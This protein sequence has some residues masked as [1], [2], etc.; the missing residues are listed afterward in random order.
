MLCILL[1]FI[2]RDTQI[3]RARTLWIP[4]LLAGVWMA[5][6]LQTVKIPEGLLA[7]IAPGSKAAYFDWI[8]DTIRAE[9]FKLQ[10]SNVESLASTWASTSIAP[11]LTMQALLALSLF[12]VTLFL[13]ITLSKSRH[14]IVLFLSSTCISGAVMALFA[15]LHARYPNSSTFAS[16]MFEA[17]LNTKNPFGSFINANNAAG[18]L[19]TALACGLGWLIF[20]T[21]KHR[22]L[23]RPG[24]HPSEQI[25]SW[26]E[27]NLQALA[28]RVRHLQGSTNAVALL[29]L[30]ILIGIIAS[31]SR[32]GLLGA[33]C[34]FTVLMANALGRKFG[35]NRSKT[36]IASTSIAVT[37]G[38]LVILGP[39]NRDFGSAVAE[40]P[41]AGSRIA[42]WRDATFA[43]WNYLPLGSG[44]GTYRYAYLPHQQYGD[45]EWFLN[46][47]NIYLEWIVEGGI[48]LLPTLAAICFIFAAFLQKLEDLHPRPQVRAILVTGW[49]MLI[50]LGVSQAFDFALLIPSNYI[51]VAMIVGSV[52]G[53]LD[54]NKRQPRRRSAQTR[55]HRQVKKQELIRSLPPRS[56]H[57]ESKPQLK[58]KSRSELSIQ[59]ATIALVAFLASTLFSAHRQAKAAS[60]SADILQSDD[61]TKSERF[62]EHTI[63]HFAQATEQWVEQIPSASTSPELH[64]K[65]ADLILTQE[66]YY[67][68]NELQKLG[69][70]YVTSWKSLQPQSLRRIHFNSLQN[71]SPEIRARNLFN[72]VPESSR[73]QFSS[74]RKHALEALLRCPLSLNARVALIE[75][76]FV[77]PEASSS[78]HDLLLQLVKLQRRNPKPIA[79]VRQMAEV[80]PGKKT[81]AAMNRFSL[82]QQQ[83]A[84]PDIWANVLRE[85]EL[86]TAKQNARRPV[87]GI[88]RTNQESGT[89]TE[90]N[91]PRRQS[92]VAK[93]TLDF[94]IDSL[95]QNATL[96]IDASED[97]KT[98]VEIKTALLAKANELLSDSTTQVTRDGQT[99]FDKGRL[100]E[101]Q[102]SLTSAIQHYETAIK[103]NPSKH[104]WRFRLVEALEQQQEYK[105]AE[106]HL[107]RCL[108]Q[109]PRN[110][111]Y[112]NKLRSLHTK[113]NT[114]RRG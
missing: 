24:I 87:S 47:D 48:W 17:T 112:R 4:G 32:G 78:S 19:N 84:F 42:H 7:V 79:W 73:N 18:Y 25:G 33:T 40:D 38:L 105:F 5:G 2:I 8:P 6:N 93:D 54:K 72:T 1:P 21:T 22:E 61:F 35:W 31:G 46:A 86:E 71:S 52:I 90:P 64:L 20:L 44:I 11:W 68:A 97:A 67:L 37:V 56:E 80:H 43:A 111:Q 114:R 14:F 83:A 108:L 3:V 41:T 95:P 81:I 58:P 51:L 94:A 110:E 82:E 30:V 26:T 65:A 75:L 96:L 85:V 70:S 55:E 23:N 63:D 100:M 99:D 89:L 59:F 34:G 113:T 106:E 12:S 10:L 29:C 102:G 77:S 13:S 36:V 50:S 57:T 103:A 107:K 39:F 16:G 98:P 88:S 104:A 62:D 74:A 76:D 27:R 101:L 15:T 91:V 109:S 69:V 53:C 28:A 45:I 9:A 92:T 66:R 60:L 49:F